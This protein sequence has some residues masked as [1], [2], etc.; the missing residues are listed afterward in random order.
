MD[1]DWIEDDPLGITGERASVLAEA[2][3][4]PG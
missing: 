3:L 1:R 4:K 2:K